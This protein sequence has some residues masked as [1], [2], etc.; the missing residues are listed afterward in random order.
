MAIN[1][2]V[3]QVGALPAQDSWW[4]SARSRSVGS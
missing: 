3:E 1:P 4:T 2:T